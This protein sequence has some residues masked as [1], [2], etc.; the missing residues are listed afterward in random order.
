MSTS[1]VKSTASRVLWSSGRLIAKKNQYSTLMGRSISDKRM[2][3]AMHDIRSFKKQWAEYVSQ[4]QTRLRTNI[5]AAANDEIPRN[6][7]RSNLFY[8]F[9]DICR[10]HTINPTQTQT[11]GTLESTLLQPV[12]APVP[13]YAHLLYTVQYAS[14]RSH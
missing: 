1:R 8:W 14:P 6:S 3:T 4:C 10:S 13:P 7:I 2:E 9:L 11:L 5:V 12:P